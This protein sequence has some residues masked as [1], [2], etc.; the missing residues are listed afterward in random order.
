VT[1]LFP[2]SSLG[3]NVL[4]PALVGGCW[5]KNL[6]VAAPESPYLAFIVGGSAAVRGCRAGP[7]A[8]QRPARRRWRRDSAHQARLPGR[9]AGR[10]RR[11]ARPPPWPL[12]GVPPAVL[13]PAHQALLALL[14]LRANGLASVPASTAAAYRWLARRTR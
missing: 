13:R 9:P 6:N 1:E 14:D 2:V 7:G 4:I 11:P 5:A 10:L 12:P 3:H 8:A